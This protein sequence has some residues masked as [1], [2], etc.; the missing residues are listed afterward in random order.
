V[1][2]VRAA[3]VSQGSR[4]RDLVNYLTKNY[5]TKIVSEQL[6]SVELVS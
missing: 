1:A 5:L 6:R 4:H 2:R 3:Q